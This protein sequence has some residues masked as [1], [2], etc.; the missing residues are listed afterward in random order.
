M[1]AELQK[2]LG[3]NNREL[4]SFVSARAQVDGMR[5]SVIRAYG[6]LLDAEAAWL[7]PK[8]DGA[9]KDELAGVL[10][11]KDA[12]AMKLFEANGVAGSD[13]KRQDAM[14]GYTKLRARLQ[15]LRAQVAD[16]DANSTGAQIDALWK[17]AESAD[18]SAGDARALVDA[19]SSRE[20]EAVRAR[21]KATEDKVRELRDAIN[22]SEIRTGDVASKVVRK[23]LL[24]L[25]DDIAGDVLA[26]DKGIVDVYWIQKTESGE[27]MEQF[28]EEQSEQLQSIDDRYRRLRQNLEE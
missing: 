9:G 22:R 13:A 18:G 16:G 26:A 17:K 4:S 6:R 19:G 25:R 12:L 11:E 10:A 23:G 27:D 3:G 24:R 1:I 2:A 20:V 21:L 14:L 7:K 15:K 5:G 28:A 8:V